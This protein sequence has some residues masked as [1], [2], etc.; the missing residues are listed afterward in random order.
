MGRIFEFRHVAMWGIGQSRKLSVSRKLL[1]IIRWKSTEKVSLLYTFTSNYEKLQN[2]ERKFAD[3]FRLYMQIGKIYK[4]IDFF[5]FWFSRFWYSKLKEY[6][7]LTPQLDFHRN[8]S[9]SFR[10]TDNFRLCPIPHMATWRNSK[11]GPVHFF[12]LFLSLLIAKKRISIPE[13]LRTQCLQEVMVDLKKIYLRNEKFPKILNCENIEFFIGSMVNR[14]Q[15][16][17][18]EV[19]ILVKHH[20]VALGGEKG[21]NFI[22]TIEHIFIY[23][24]K[25]LDQ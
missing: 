2:R 25:A 14:P 16:S 9:S 10:E 11:I 19:K 5:K 22:L 1:D 18:F 20:L 24:S 23:H 8:P 12:S 4:K 21:Q 13:M 17:D 15:K 6:R 3:F 7:K